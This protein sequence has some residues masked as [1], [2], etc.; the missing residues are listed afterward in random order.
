MS[1]LLK[2]IGSAEEEQPGLAEIRSETH[3]EDSIQ[4]IASSPTEEDGFQDDTST[5]G[6]GD[7]TD[8]ERDQGTFNRRTN[9]SR[10]RRSKR[11]NVQTKDKPIGTEACNAGCINPWKRWNCAD[12]EAQAPEHIHPLPTKSTDR[13]DEGRYNAHGGHLLE[14]SHSDDKELP[15][16]VNPFAGKKLGLRLPALL[17]R[18]SKGNKD[19]RG[20]EK[21]DE[22]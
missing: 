13:H 11:Y 16:C 3:E 6:M 19:T 5:T 9:P 1:N 20:R 2:K 10:R 22:K 14:P 4:R 12:E 17:S 7:F 21:R 8:D 15:G 18:Q